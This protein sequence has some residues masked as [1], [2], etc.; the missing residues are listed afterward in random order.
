MRAFGFCGVGA[1]HA[2]PGGH[3]FKLGGRAAKLGAVVAVVA[4][5]SMGLGG[6]VGAA[7]DSNFAYARTQGNFSLTWG[8]PG[9]PFHASFG[10]KAAVNVSF[11]V[12]G[13]AYGP[14]GFR[15]PSEQGP[16]VADPSAANAS[17]SYC[18]GCLTNAIAINVDVVSGPTTS[19]FAPTKAVATDTYCVGCNT[20]AADY[21]FVV[22]LGTVAF[23]T[24]QGLSALDAIA[25]AL[26][27][28]ANTPEQSSVLAAQVEAQLAAIQGVL[29]PGSAT[30]DPVSSP[31]P[32]AVP[33]PQAQSAAVPVP[34]AQSAAVPAPQAQSAAVPAPAPAPQ[35][36]PAVQQFGAT[37][38]S[39]A[40]TG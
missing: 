17:S 31:Q 22:A 40:V 34:Q 29:Q 7:T 27:A 21:T 37:Q 5:L 23:L 25:S 19:V 20:L 1:R 26:V 13:Q 14:G 38:Y 16:T 4:G 9:I 2:H 28:D 36:Q 12:N 33:V 10:S 6:T 35:A 39:N 30:L 15:V 11:R 32:A 3:G 18:H 8:F 24:P